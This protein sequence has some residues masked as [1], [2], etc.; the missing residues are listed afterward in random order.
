MYICSV[1]LYR[2]YLSVYSPFLLIVDAHSVVCFD[3]CV[4]GGWTKAMCLVPAL[5]H[6]MVWVFYKSREHTKKIKRTIK[7]YKMCLVSNR[8]ATSSSTL[9]IIIPQSHWSVTALVSL[10]LWYNRV[11]T[12]STACSFVPFDTKKNSRGTGS[13]FDISQH[14]RR[15]SPRF[16]I[17]ETTVCNQCAL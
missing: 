16:L 13:T 12:S 11:G 1:L 17:S 4:W 9:G 7:M 3:A 14:E 10:G 6:E 15:V 5:S 2:C 8:P